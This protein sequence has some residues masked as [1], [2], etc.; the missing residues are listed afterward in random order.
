MMAIGLS[1]LNIFLLAIL[2]GVSQSSLLLILI[3]LMI[4]LTLHNASNFFNDEQGLDYIVTPTYST[5]YLDMHLYPFNLFLGDAYGALIPKVKKNVHYFLVCMRFTTI[6]LYGLVI[7]I[8]ILATIQGVF[9]N[10]WT[11]VFSMFFYTCV[12]AVILRWLRN[13]ER[14]NNSNMTFTYKKLINQYYENEDL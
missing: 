13:L 1:W 7:G 8:F 9:P 12:Y 6:A 3:A 5:I 10:V 11:I 4:P 14:K 2:I